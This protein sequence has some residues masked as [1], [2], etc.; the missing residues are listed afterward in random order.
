MATIL[1]VSVSSLLLS[2]LFCS[3]KSSR[4]DRFLFEA[5]SGDKETE[6]VVPCAGPGFF[7]DSLVFRASALG[8]S[9]DLSVSKGKAMS[10]ARAYLAAA[11]QT[12]VRS[13]NDAYVN[14]RES[15][16]EAQIEERF[17][18][19]VREVVSQELKGIRVI[20]ERYFRAEEGKFKTYVAIELSAT[21]LVKAYHQRLADNQRVSEEFDFERFRKSFAHGMQ[22]S[23]N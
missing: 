13:V 21:G 11:I 3:C 18:S 6:I 14:T 23:N 19:I 17:E 22:R 9:I 7:T 12:T 5:P 4:A 8:E 16:N 20:C 10:N 2:C 1:K 15:N